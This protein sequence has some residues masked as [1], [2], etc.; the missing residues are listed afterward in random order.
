MPLPYPAITKIPNTEPA[1]IPALWNNTY[2]QIDANFA[3]AALRLDNIEAT[4]VVDLGDLGITIP[5]TKINFLSTVTSDVQTQINGK[6]ATPA[7]TTAQYVRGDGSLAAFPTTWA[8]GSISGKP[9]TFATSGMT[10]AASDVPTLNQNTTGSA[11]TLTTARTLT[12]GATGKTFNGSANVAW[13]LGEIGAAAVVHTHVIGDVTGLQ[14]ALDGKATGA[15][16]HALDSLSNVTIANNSTGSLLAWNGTAWVN[17]TLAA[18]GVSAVGHTHVIGDVTGLQTALNAKLDSGANAVSATKLATARTLT[19]GATARSFDGSANLS[20]TL[21]DLGAA[22]ISHSHVISDVTGLQ[23]ALDSKA[24]SAHN[25]TLDALSNVTVTNNSTGE[26]L[27][28]AGTAWVNATLAEA[29][30]AAVSHTHVVSDVTGLQGALDGKL[31]TTG[32]AAAATRLATARTITLGNTARSFDGTANMSWTLGEM[33]AA[34][35]G[36]N[37]NFADIT[38]SRGNGTG[39]IFLGDGSHYVFWDGGSYQMPGGQLVVE[40]G[41][42]K[43]SSRELKNIDGPMPYGLAELMQ[44]ETAI[45]SYK[46]EFIDEDGRKRLFVVAEQLQKIVPEPVFSEAIQFGERKVAAVDDGQLVPL[47]IKS[48]QELAQRLFEVEGRA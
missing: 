1:A 5:A 42:Q 28:W 11:A 12:I 48:V 31:A 38:A 33:G 18:A 25:H 14:A 34:G 23:G 26:I 39:V 36:A 24:G 13:T 8:W 47:L 17:Q 9:T 10:L 46:P 41:F 16:N 45:G 37:V 3:S 15:H 30:I 19:L 27:R 2:V 22:A 7:G 4:M 20:W 44:I 32:T 6:F 35:L 40:G 29:G 21:A 43:G